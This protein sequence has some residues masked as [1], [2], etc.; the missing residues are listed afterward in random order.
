M[1]RLGAVALAAACLASAAQA[2][3]LTQDHRYEVDGKTFEGYVATNTDVT[4]KGTVLIVHDWDGL[5]DYEKRRAEMLAALGYTVFAIDVYGAD[6]NPQSVEE[7]RALS[8]ALYGDR[9]TFR[10][11]LMGSIAEADNI[12][13]ATEAKVMQGYCFGGAA[14][15]EAARAGADLDGFVSF[16]GGLGTPEGQDY[17]ATTAPVMLFHGS[18]DP[19]SGMDAMAAALSQMQEAGVEHGA[20]V[21]GGARHSF[22][23][24]GSDDYDL[25]ADRGAWDGLLDFLGER[26]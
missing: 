1:I 15:L 4:P 23:V 8:G 14:V 9:E 21:F 12:P 10:A 13:G 16:H 18:A 25:E 19:V 3:L 26:L 7:N 11:R 2:E 22:T 24:W 6:E 5:T 17:S 20:Q